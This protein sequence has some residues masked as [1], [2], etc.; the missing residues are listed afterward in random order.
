MARKIKGFFRFTGWV[1]LISVFALGLGIFLAP[2][3]PLSIAPWLQ[4]L[5]PSLAGLIFLYAIFLIFF[6]FRSRWIW[7]GISL[8]YVLISGLLIS[9]NIQSDTKALPTDTDQFTVLTYNLGAFRLNERKVDQI[10]D[11]LKEQN[12]DI[13]AFQELRNIE[14]D[15]VGRTVNYFADK[16]GLPYSHFLNLPSHLHG[17]A[18]ISRYPILETDTLYLPEDEINSGMIA[19]IETPKGL[20]S[21]ANLHMSS[22]QFFS[23]IR[24]ADGRLNK[25]KAFLKRIRDVLWLQEEKFE[26]IFAKLDASPHPVILVGDF[27]A[28]SH[29][30]LSQMYRSRLSDAFLEVGVGKGWTYPLRRRKGSWGMRLD[31]LYYSEGVEALRAERIRRPISDHFPLQ[32]TF[33]LP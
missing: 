9:Q 18:I 20:I 8:G 16:L 33:R 23:V 22:Y 5:S 3:L 2:Y 25:F 15:T 29:S 21:L 4:V 31:Y 28:P 11:F 24:R 17:I 7:A 19:T 26:K 12:P 10:V 13:I 1:F 30:R 14:I 6:L 32:G 27:N